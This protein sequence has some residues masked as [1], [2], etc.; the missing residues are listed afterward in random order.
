MGRAL[1]IFFLRAAH[2]K[3]AFS[4]GNLVWSKMTFL[5]IGSGIYT[6]FGEKVSFLAI[7]SDF[8]TWFGQKWHFLADK[9]VF[10]PFL[11]EKS[12]IFDHSQW[13]FNSAKSRLKKTEEDHT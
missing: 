2:T 8:I 4:C 10:I 5:A 3:S 11:G 7:L 6:L 13:F 9:V 1:P 12:A